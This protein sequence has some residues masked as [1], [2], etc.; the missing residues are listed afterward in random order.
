[1]F[2]TALVPEQ[3]ACKNPLPSKMNWLSRITM[4]EVN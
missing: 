1:M 2:L 4:A 3:V